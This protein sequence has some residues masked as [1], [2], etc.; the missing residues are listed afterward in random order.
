MAFVR[1][2]QVLGRPRYYFVE[3]RREGSKVRQRV[4][5]YLG[6]CRTLDEAIALQAEYT[7]RLRDEVLKWRGDS[8]L[9]RPPARYARCVR[10]SRQGREWA[11]YMGAKQQ[12]EKVRRRVSRAGN[13]MRRL[14][15]AKVAAKD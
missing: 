3:N 9:R 14:R 5:A 8:R 7:E 1:T 11:V 4:L 2:K 15:A 13:R 12:R 6:Q 10:Q